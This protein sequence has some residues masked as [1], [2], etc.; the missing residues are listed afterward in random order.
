M[1]IRG[2]H[3]VF[4]RIFL[5]VI[6]LIITCSSIAQTSVL[7]TAHFKLR[8]VINIPEIDSTFVDN[9]SRMMD[10]RD[11]LQMVRNC[12][13]IK[14][15]DV[16]FRGTASPDGTYDF[17]V[18]LSEN[19]L[20]TFKE[21]VRSYVDIPDSVI[22][23]NMSDIP[24]DEFRNKVAESDMEHRDEVLSIIDEEPRLVPFYGN[25]RIDAR[26]LKLKKMYK[27]S[28]WEYLKSPILRDLRYGDAIFS[29]EYVL[30]Y[31][32]QSVMADSVIMPQA[33]FQPVD[34]PEVWMPRCY[35]KTNFVR[36]A[37]LNANLAFEIDFARHW[38]FTL[39]VSYCAMDWFKSTIKFRNFTVQPEF[40][41][42]FRHWDN[43]GF[44]VGAHFE[45]CYYNYAFN[46][47]YRYQDYKGQTPALGGGVS[48]GYRKPISANRRWRLEFAAGAGV[49]PLDY[50]VF[51]N[52]LDVRDGQWIE[53]RKKTYIGLDEVAITLSYSFD[54]RRFQ[55]ITYKKGGVK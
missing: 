8:Y 53:R 54:L 9:A 4:G 20:R 13:F 55:R 16:R 44:F 50:S 51:H 1:V 7:D 10:M 45:L 21:L 30:P 29:F 40:R 43:D 15:K 11:F 19:R 14:I 37:M 36:L 2:E 27:G 3:T 22:H 42:W 25:R 26:L 49:Y 23:A 24:W 17:N 35:V 41:Y 18:W 12:G 28:V 34:I 52:T 33:L 38:S 46:G 47:K 48:F 5:F 31:A 39:P 6:S 32:E